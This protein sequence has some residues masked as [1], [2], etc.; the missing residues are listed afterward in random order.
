MGSTDAELEGILQKMDNGIRQLNSETNER[1][2]VFL[3]GMTGAGKSTVALLLTSMSSLFSCKRYA[4]S[5]RFIIQDLKEKISTIDSQSKTKAPEILH[6]PELGAMIY[7]CPGFADTNSTDELTSAYFIKHALDTS[8]KVKFLLVAPFYTLEAGG[9]R[10]DFSN[11]LLH[12]VR[13]VKNVE[14]YADSFA[15]AVTFGNPLHPSNYTI[16][17]VVGFLQGYL[18]NELQRKFHGQED[19][20]NSTRALLDSLLYQDE[21]GTYVAIGVLRSPTQHGRLSD[22]QS[23]RDD[24]GQL[25]RVLTK[26][27]IYQTAD[28]QDFG[29]SV[30]EGGKL[31]AVDLA[32]KIDE[33][34]RQHMYHFWEGTQ[35]H[36]ETE[37]HELVDPIEDK[38]IIEES[39][40][41][42]TRLLQFF[43]DRHGVN[44][45][46][47][48]RPKQFVVH[49]MS[50]MASLRLDLPEKTIPDSVLLQDGH[51]TFLEKL[52]G[53]SWKPQSARWVQGLEP[54]VKFLEMYKNWA[55]E[56][57][58]LEQRLATYE[59]QVG[60]YCF[61]EF[62]NE[63]GSIDVTPAAVQAFKSSKS[64]PQEGYAAIKN[65]LTAFDS[66]NSSVSRTV[67]FRQLNPILEYFVSGCSSIHC[68]SEGTTAKV[69]GN[70]I[71]T[72]K[73][74]ANSCITASIKKIV[75]YAWDTFFFD[76]AVDAKS[77]T[78][79]D[80]FALVVIANQLRSLDHKIDLSG[81]D[82][83]RQGLTA[84]AESKDG[85][86]G[87]D[88]ERGGNFFGFFGGRHGQLFVE[89][90][91][92]N[93]ADGQN[94]GKGRN[95]RNGTF[96]ERADLLNVKV[97]NNWQSGFSSYVDSC[98]ITPLSK[99]L[100]YDV[101]Y[102]GRCKARF[103]KT[104]WSYILTFYGSPGSP[105]LKGGNGGNSGIGGNPG[106]GRIYHISGKNLSSSD[107]HS[108]CGSVGTPGQGGVGGRGGQSRNA[109]T[110]FR[111]IEPHLSQ[112]GR[113]TGSP[114]GL[115]CSFDATEYSSVDTAPEGDEGHSGVSPNSC[116]PS[117]SLNPHDYTFHIGAY[118]K[119]AKAQLT[120]IPA[121][122]RLLP[123]LMN[124]E[125]NTIVDNEFFSPTSVLSD[126]IAL[127]ELLP[128]LLKLPGTKWNFFYTSILN[129]ITGM[130]ANRPSQQEE[131]AL[132]EAASVAYGRLVMLNKKTAKSNLITDLEG[133]IDHTNQILQ[134]IRALETSSNAASQVTATK[135]KF[136]QFIQSRINE[137]DDIIDTVIEPEI[138]KIEEELDKK[139]EFMLQ[140]LIE[141]QITAVEW[142]NELYAQ[143]FGATVFL[144]KIF[145]L[146]KIGARALGVFGKKG[147][148][149]GAAVYAASSV[150][151]SFLPESD[152]PPSF[153]ATEKNKALT[154]YHQIAKQ[155]LQ[156]EEERLRDVKSM[157]EREIANNTAIWSENFQGRRQNIESMLAK[158]DDLSAGVKRVENSDHHGSD[159]ELIESLG[160]EATSIRTDIGAE[161]HAVEDSLK[162]QAT[163]TSHD[164]L[165][166][167]NFLGH[168]QTLLAVLSA[169]FKILKVFK[170][171]DPK[172]TELARAE[173]V[174]KGYDA[175]IE[176]VDSRMPQILSKL[177]QISRAAM[178]IARNQSSGASLDVSGW[179]F[180]STLD[181]LSSEIQI[182]ILSGV[183]IDSQVMASM[184]KLKEAFRTLFMAC[185]RMQDY[186]AERRM[187]NFISDSLLSTVESVPLG[188][189]LELHR[190]LQQLKLMSQSNL[191]LNCWENIEHSF[192]LYVFPY[193]DL[194][195]SQV[196]NSIS[197]QDVLPLPKNLTDLPELVT[198]ISRRNNEL[199]RKLVNFRT[200]IVPELHS[201]QHE[202]DFSLRSPFYTWNSDQLKADLVHLLAGHPINLFADVQHAPLHFDAVKFKSV[203]LQLISGNS[204]VNTSLQTVL[205][206][207][208]V[209]MTHSGVNNYRLVV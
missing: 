63:S 209:N 12:V 174:L 125:T 187:A 11:L 87:A 108:V 141:E 99:G 33:A 165:G 123:F 189:D 178:K 40:R 163:N 171:K 71:L 183:P 53:T 97:T 16:N 101:R 180:Q 170:H 135:Q 142:R 56:L 79:N 140:Q 186:V 86:H 137:V 173:K 100:L 202:G 195:L 34:I 18:D 81:R 8:R 26:D 188:W 159:Y 27:T 98:K 22:I 158:V 96:V 129:R 104:Q 199:K 13:T 55:N 128:S 118:K 66:G 144:R 111:L 166:S 203:H 143:Q 191:V 184:E 45:T 39:L 94:G 5:Q 20:L 80:T 23:A 82:G 115:V 42:F 106:V 133:Y 65:V 152:I 43:R 70:F 3:L 205:G 132:R 73:L 29:Y 1:D 68:T 120:A 78:A 206:S 72:S 89:L 62:R 74:K 145:G 105:G 151:E 112:T 136:A 7:D 102:P 85:A 162:G 134:E 107:I 50:T 36:Y 35:R 21:N 76:A 176:A 24:R 91:G 59:F 64:I 193:A 48:E 208:E 185:D 51:V 52:M 30:S 92:G 15:L 69:T 10:H 37:M 192:R 131:S 25:L 200:M 164:N 54:I 67:N 103:P 57:V 147:A 149:A 207:F 2:N 146:L 88:G 4:F 196:P 150:A 148:A 60:S 28:P 194:Y 6:S 41:V 181:D 130:L 75:I 95:G 175:K 179:Q 84:A 157:Y 93:G 58:Q 182:H 201:D 109:T 19:I 198:E 61:P 124:M 117:P 44:N 153:M 139:M 46:S 110:C 161:L 17:S 168:V 204:T 126:L 49:L 154:W 155:K 114:S 83:K 156:D 172:L 122:R 190:N 14:K 127:E 160:H 113:P 197:D 121:R 90:K 177:N 47:T 31:L 32:R 77:M 169:E 138:E 119:A 9:N 38:H 167:G 116:E